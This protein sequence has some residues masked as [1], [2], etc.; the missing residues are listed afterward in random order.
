MTLPASGIIKFSNLNV[1]FNRTST[2]TISLNSAFAG[3]YAQ[4][5]DINRNTGAG[6]NID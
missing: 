3:T 6:Q 2:S 5:G 4:Y 1:E